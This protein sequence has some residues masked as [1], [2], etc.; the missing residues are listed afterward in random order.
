MKEYT[1]RYTLC[2]PGIN[3]PIMWTVANQP[4]PVLAKVIY[5]LWDR[6]QVNLEDNTPLLW[7][8]EVLD[9]HGRIIDCD[10]YIKGYWQWGSREEHAEVAK[11][12]YMDE[13]WP[14]GLHYPEHDPA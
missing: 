2:V 6:Y 14:E 7:V 3:V 9:S 10:C 11:E 1:L 8:Y 12:F 5:D 13:S 4:A